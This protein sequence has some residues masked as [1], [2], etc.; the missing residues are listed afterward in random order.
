[1]RMP[2]KV[3]HIVDNLDRCAVEAWLIHMLDCAKARGLALDWTFYCTVGQPGCRDDKARTLGAR[4]IYSPVPIGAKVAFM[5]ALRTEL[6]RGRYD[7]LHSHHDLISGIYFIAAMGLSIRRRVVHIHNADE[8]VLT[9]NRA[10]Q[11]MLRPVLRRICLNAADRVIAVSSH[12]LNTFLAGCR[13][14]AERD[15]VHYYGIDAG[16]FQNL[17]RDRVGLRMKLG[18]PAE[19]KILLFPARLVPEKNPLFAV[20]VLAELRKRQPETVLVFAG[21]GALEAAILDRSRA[22]HQ[23][24][25][26]RMMGW[27]DDI[28]EIMAASDWFILPHP[29]HPMEGFGIAVVEAQLAGLRMLLSRGVSDAPLLPTASYRMLPLAAGAAAWSEAAMDLLKSS[30]LSRRDALKALKSSPMD[31]DKALDALLNIYA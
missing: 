22:L 15:R 23:D 12:A 1:M 10:K 28:P 31:V 26:V 6:R 13:A 2:C 5:R 21:S 19:A 27:R 30:P 3:L 11:A 14:N 25:A 16:R 9:P 20:D 24:E 4:I 7:V 29:E 18:L 8:H 17:A